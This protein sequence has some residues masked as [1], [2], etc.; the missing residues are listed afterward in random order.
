MP[1]AAPV[2]IKVVG[3]KEFQRDMKKLSKDVPKR[4][5]KELKEAG[6]PVRSRAEALAL[7]SI[8]N[9]GDRWS[10]IKT[11]AT[12]KSVYIAPRARPRGGTS[13]ANLAPMLFTQAM[14]PAAVDGLDDVYA[15]FER[16]VD[17]IRRDYF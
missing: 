16:M 11:G 14:L 1:A 9:I 17:D 10:Q 8:T 12:A 15:G 7:S 2:K 5:R 3:L 13:R 6:E 4:V